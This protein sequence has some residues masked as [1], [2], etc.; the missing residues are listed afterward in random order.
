MQEK[1]CWNGE[2][3]SQ[4]K[5]KAKKKS[6]YKVRESKKK[7][8]TVE[9]EDWFSSKHWIYLGVCSGLI[10]IVLYKVA[11]TKYSNWKRQIRNM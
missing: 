6:T 5:G 10:L 3:S 9:G 4:L 1:G 11:A 8:R 7:A 2:V